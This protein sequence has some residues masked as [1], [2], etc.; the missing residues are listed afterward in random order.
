MFQLSFANNDRVAN[1]VPQWGASFKSFTIVKLV[2]GWLVG[3]VHSLMHAC[4]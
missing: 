4:Y 3:P 2:L 1:P